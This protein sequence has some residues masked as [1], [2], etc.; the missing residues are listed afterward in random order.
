MARLEIAPKTQP[1]IELSEQLVTQLN[2]FLS[3]HPEKSLEALLQDA[4]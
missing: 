4:L 3:E 2:S 1:T